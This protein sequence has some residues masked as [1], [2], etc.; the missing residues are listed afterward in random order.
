VREAQAG[1]VLPH[2]NPSEIA[3][4]VGVLAREPAR[5]REMGQRGRMASARFSL[6]SNARDVLAIYE[7]LVA[8]R[9]QLARGASRPTKS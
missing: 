9:S 2:G 3:E 7:R 8:Q 1:L 6:E 5:R 4:A